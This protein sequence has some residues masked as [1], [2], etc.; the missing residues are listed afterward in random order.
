MRAN[1]GPKRNKTAKALLNIY[2]AKDIL[3]EDQEL[4]Q[5]TLSD[6]KSRLNLISTKKEGDTI[7]SSGQRIS[8]A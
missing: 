4:F 2:E 1:F 3:R 5:K 6:L 7:S 8:E